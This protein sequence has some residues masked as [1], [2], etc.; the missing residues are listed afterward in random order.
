VPPDTAIAPEARAAGTRPNGLVYPLA[1]LGI[2]TPLASPACGLL[3]IIGATCYV[4]ARGVAGIAARFTLAANLL[5]L[6]VYVPYFYRD[7]WF[8]IVPLVLNAVFAATILA[9]GVAALG[10][11]IRQVVNAHTAS[12]GTESSTDTSPIGT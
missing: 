3:G 2:E 11:R 8:M 12:T 9:A 7:D 1:L 5:T 4:G 6:L 10:G